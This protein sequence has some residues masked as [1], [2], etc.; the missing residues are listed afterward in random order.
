MKRVNLSVLAAVL[1][2]VLVPG[3]AAGA[4]PNLGQ[5]VGVQQLATGTTAIVQTLG[6]PP[7]AAVEL[8][9]RAPSTGFGAKPVPSLARL[10]AQTIAAS[11]PLVGSALSE[12]V[13]NSGGRLA[14]SVY[15]DSI[16]IAAVVPANAARAV[17]KAMT[18]AYFAPV[19]HLR[20]ANTRR[21]CL[22]S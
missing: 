20:C 22:S 3:S 18:T 11:K 15:G 16:E 8:W 6:G 2:A 1:V 4:L 17:V 9:F 7:V 19:R 13:K 12:V 21:C 5:N 14:I 10:A